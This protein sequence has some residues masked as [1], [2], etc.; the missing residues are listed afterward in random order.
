[1]LV[2]LVLQVCDAIV[3]EYANEMLMFPTTPA[4]WRCIADKFGQRWNFHHCCGAIDG[5]HIAIKKPAKSGSHFFS[6]K[7][8]YSIVLLALVDSEYKFLSVNVGVQGSCS[9]AGVYNHSSLVEPRLRNGTLGLPNPEPLPRDDRDTGYF[10]VGDDAFALRIYMMKPYP[11]YNLDHDQ[12]IFNYR[13]SRARRVV[14]NAFGILACHFRCLLSTL[15]TNHCNA[16]KITKACVVLHNIMRV[17]YPGLQ[18][19][20]LDVEVDDGNFVPGAWRN[21]GVLAEMEE[22]GRAPVQQE[23]TRCCE[24][25]LRT[26]FAVRQVVYHGRMQ[27]S[28]WVPCIEL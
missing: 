23:V 15:Q 8:F 14:E 25:I 18:N 13:C 11:H 16:R 3:A 10:L 7:G 27:P 22:V 26:T 21:A 24:F 17:R 1:M 2:C 28:R 12:R 6:Y 5:K 20:D 4:E 19:A 9:D